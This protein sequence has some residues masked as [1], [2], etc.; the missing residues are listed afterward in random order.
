LRDALLPVKTDKPVQAPVAIAAGRPSW[1][2][3]VSP[4]EEQL[5]RIADEIEIRNTLDTDEAPMRKRY[6]G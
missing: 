1:R 5:R 6:C 3:P 2:A 4:I